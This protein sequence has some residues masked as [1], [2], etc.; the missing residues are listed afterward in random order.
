[1]SKAQ[2]SQL[3]EMGWNDVL[4]NLKRATAA[5]EQDKRKFCQNLIDGKIPTANND[6]DYIDGAKEAAQAFLNGEQMEFKGPDWVV[7]DLEKNC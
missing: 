3:F 7:T 6:G 1:M 4:G 2:V 5:S